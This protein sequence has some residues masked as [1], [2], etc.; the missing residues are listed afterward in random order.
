MAGVAMVKRRLAIGRDRPMDDIIAAA[1]RNRDLDP[2]KRPIHPDGRPLSDV[3]IA[4][5]IAPVIDPH[6]DWSPQEIETKRRAVAR[7]FERRPQVQHVR[8]AWALTVDANLVR[9]LG[10][11]YDPA[12]GAISGSAWGGPPE[13]SMDEAPDPE[14]R[15]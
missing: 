7:Y 13:P 11:H 8:G 10:L 4:R 2:D 14:P 9:R 1:L 15:F 12:T 5:M 6:R 3:R